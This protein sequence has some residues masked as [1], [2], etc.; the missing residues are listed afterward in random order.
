ML[1]VSDLEFWLKWSVAKTYAD[2]MM[3]RTTAKSKEEL[4][5]RMEED[6]TIMHL[7]KITKHYA[8]NFVFKHFV[9]KESANRKLSKKT[10]NFGESQLIL[11]FDLCDYYGNIH[12][13]S[14]RLTK[15]RRSRYF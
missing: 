12:E 5:S 4:I 10:F 9:L 2:D 14:H 15:G 8:V 7:K 11:K 6:A 3:T 1:Y 13:W